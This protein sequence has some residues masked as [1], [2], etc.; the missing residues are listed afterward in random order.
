MPVSDPVQT[1]APEED[2]AFIED[3][4]REAGRVA[5]RYFRRD[6]EV[7]WKEGASPV[8]QADLEVDQFLREHLLQARPSYGWL[9]EETA[10]N[11]ERLLAP[12]TFV[13]DPIDGTRA[14]ID[15][16]EVWCVSVAVVENGRAIAGVLDCPASD[17]FFSAARGGGAHRNGEPI[18]VKNAGRDLA[19]A[20]PKNMMNRLPP[21][22]YAR[23]SPH[24]YVPSLAYRI[25]LV[26]SGM[27]DATFIKPASHDWDLAAADVILSEAGGS[28]VDGK[29]RR[30]QYAGPNPQL[31]ALAAGSG[32]LLRIMSGVVGKLQ[33]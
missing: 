21:A 24:P 5:M 33:G 7:W 14:F 8:S 26:A 29:H 13:V 12:R 30:P 16:R 25:G 28:I 11:K 31:G 1:H 20:G 10:D 23:V 2:L 22:L 17:E 19:L 15:G 9:S 3:A 32:D 4:A 27:L 18:R 6:P